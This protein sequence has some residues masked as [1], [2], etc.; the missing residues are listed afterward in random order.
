MNKKNLITMTRFPSTSCYVEET[1]KSEKL[2][3]C[4]VSGLKCSGRSFYTH[5]GNA[6]FYYNWHEKGRRERSLWVDRLHA[7][8]LFVRIME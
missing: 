4:L 2:Q 8:D 5:E 1:S 6:S 7:L 3:S